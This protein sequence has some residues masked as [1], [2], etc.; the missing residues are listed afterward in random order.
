MR[1]KATVNV[2]LDGDVWCAAVWIEGEFDS[3]DPI[4]GIGEDAT[5]SQAMQR[6]VEQ[7]SDRFDVDIHRVAPGDR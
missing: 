4:D 6:I 2:F 7:L 3:S 5:E 1:P